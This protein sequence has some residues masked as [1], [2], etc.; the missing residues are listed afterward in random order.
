MCELSVHSDRAALALL[1]LFAASCRNPD[2]LG[3]LRTSAIDA[4]VRY[5]HVDEFDSAE[6]IWH[7]F[8]DLQTNTGNTAPGVSIG[9]DHAWVEPELVLATERALS[10]RTWPEGT[11]VPARTVVGRATGH[12]G[13]ARTIDVVPTALLEA[14]WYAIHVSTVPIGV[15]IP[16]FSGL[17]RMLDGSFGV[18]FSPASMPSLLDGTICRKSDGAY[19]VA[20]QFSESVVAV[21]SASELIRLVHENVGGPH[22][23]VIVDVQAPRGSAQASFRCLDLREDAFL[24]I[25]VVAGIRSLVGI[26]LMAPSGAPRNEFRIR[27]LDLPF[28]RSGPR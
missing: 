14:R 24:R 15:R 26:P 25:S 4:P 5:A 17:H 2:D 11:P 6:P 28:N 8:V 16:P 18:R 1:L 23:E 27:Y 12:D 22:C 3:V 21:R 13:I 7:K 9:G 19:I 10:I 20:L